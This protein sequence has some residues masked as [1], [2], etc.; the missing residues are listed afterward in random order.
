MHIKN[1][2]SLL[3]TSAA[4]SNCA[5]VAKR[6]PPGTN[7]RLNPHRKLIATNGEFYTDDKLKGVGYWVNDE[8]YIVQVADWGNIWWVGV[9]ANGGMNVASPKTEEEAKTMTPGSFERFSGIDAGAPANDVGLVEHNKRIPRT[10]EFYVDG[11]LV[12]YGRWLDD[13]RYLCFVKGWGN[14]WW[15]GV[16]T[17]GGMNTG[18]YETREEALAGK[19][20]HFE[21]YV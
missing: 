19:P 13:G 10:A 20:T 18:T 7:L 5:A 4:F 17:K 6:D 3:L 2:L 16:P 14:L 21:A 9:L 11:G 12:G 8:R 1:V 15:I